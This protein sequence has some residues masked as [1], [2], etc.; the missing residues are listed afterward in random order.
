MGHLNNSK[1][2]DMYQI[3]N[4]YSRLLLIIVV[5]FFSCNEE[6][7][8]KET[9]LDFASSETGF[10]TYEDFNIGVANLYN[11][12]RTELAESESAIIDYQYGTDL[13]VPNEATNGPLFTNYLAY[14]TSSA[15]FVLEHWSRYYKIISAANLLI[16]RL[17][18][19]E[20]LTDDQKVDIQAKSRFFRGLAY[21]NLA[22]LYGGVPIELEEVSSPKTNYTRASRD[23]VYMQAVA[24]L[25]FASENL[26][27]I[28][29]VD[30]WEVSNLAAYHLLAEAQIALENWD[31]AIQAA[32]VVIDDPATSLMTERFGT[33]STEPGD[34]YWDLFRRGNQNRGSGNTEAIMVW[35]FEVDV[36]G[37]V[38][39]SSSRTGPLFERH[40][41]PLPGLMSI[42][43][44]GEQLFIWPASDYVGGRGIGQI[45]GSIHYLYEIWQADWF[46]M[47]NSGYNFPRDWVIS[48][49]ASQWYGDSLIAHH[50]EWWP[51]AS[52][53]TIRWLYPY[54][55]KVTTPGNHPDGLYTNKE[56][57]QLSGSAGTTYT[58]WYFIRL[59]ETYLLR[60][61]AYLGNGDA[62]NA[63]IDINTVRARANA[64][65]A[66]E[67]EIDI[68]YILDER[69]RELGPEEPRRLTLNRLGMCY[70][71]TMRYA[72][73]TGYGNNQ[74]FQVVGFN[75]QPYHDLLP[76]P[77]SEIQRNTGAVIQQNPGYSAE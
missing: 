67:S 41:A 50:S 32:S 56:L 73:P 77:F 69:L 12:S 64:D 5:I 6:V 30:D 60:A 63:V 7:I 61:E 75:I 28:V 3:S 20:E 44:D 22:H 55:T 54:P 42:G 35:Q 26:Q 72:F 9:P 74:T 11:L 34:V 53:D 19:S 37:G 47:R 48:N 59:A 17:N 8:L 71:R 16:N 51:P 2:K 76:I 10:S 70:E 52:V 14:V 38:L 15:N 27:G 65:P 57:Q 33:R 24:D 58:D 66:I 21:K 4:I 36:L 23:E 1:S 13:G 68:D 46:D 62:A 29:D 31:E 49:P 18:F 39:K 43:L 25:E 40:W 45:K